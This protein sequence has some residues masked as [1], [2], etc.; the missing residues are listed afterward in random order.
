MKISILT[1]LSLLFVKFTFIPNVNLLSWV[2]VAIGFD[3]VSGFLKAVF[4]SKKRTSN[5]TRSTFPKY[6]QYLGAI[7]LSVILGNVMPNEQVTMQ[8][9]VDAVC[10]LIVYIE[11][12]SICEN[13]IEMLPESYITR[14]FFKPLLSLLTISIEKI[15]FKKEKTTAIVILIVGLSSCRVI[16]PG[17]NNT[18]E[19]I[20]ST[21]ITYKQVSY[22]VKGA[23]VSNA[24]NMDSLFQVLKASLKPASTG[25]NLDSLFSSFT[26]SL[27]T[28]HDTT[29]VTDP[30][31]K[32]Q[33]KY[34][35]DAYGKLQMSCTSKDE[36]IQLLVAEVKN[37]RKEISTSK[38]TIVDYKMPRW[39][40]LIIGGCI[41]LGLIGLLM[42]IIIIAQSKGW[43]K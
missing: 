39:G 5:K 16:R 28:K 36:T 14:I 20:D 3:F 13:F 10:T 33:L 37:L 24:I 26:A 6:L 35:Y 23:S 19:K 30:N 1:Y 32:V 9:A 41:C 34:W 40:W 8:Y 27:N 2:L 29:M 42:I 21:Y 17:I 18:I 4:S 31:T 11:S 15:S 22:A 7:L 43:I 12:M 38:Q 25:T